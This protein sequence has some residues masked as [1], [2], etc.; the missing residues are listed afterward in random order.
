M[1]NIIIIALIL[2]AGVMVWQFIIANRDASDHEA[3]DS[4]RDDV[5]STEE[6]LDETEEFMRRME[7]LSKRSKNDDDDKRS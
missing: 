7:R 1:N 6:S 3:S 2:A 4:W 5:D